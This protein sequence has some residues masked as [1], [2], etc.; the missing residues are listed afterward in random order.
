[1]KTLF[2][3]DINNSQTKYFVEATDSLVSPSWTTNG[4]NR[5]GVGP[6]DTEFNLVTN[7]VSMAVKNQQF[8]WL[9]IQ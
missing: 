1:M 5:V 7:R 3:P 8:I 6:L 9:R 4:V 2:R